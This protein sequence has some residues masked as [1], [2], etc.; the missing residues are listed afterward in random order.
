M[1]VVLLFYILYLYFISDYACKP[2][3]F[4]YRIISPQHTPVIEDQAVWVL[5]KMYYVGSKAENNI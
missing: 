4:I 1:L 3:G 5:I 2:Y